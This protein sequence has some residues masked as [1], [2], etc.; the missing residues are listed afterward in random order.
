MFGTFDPNK[1][2]D[3]QTNQ[4]KGRYNKTKIDVILS[5]GLVMIF[6]ACY[7]FCLLCLQKLKL[8]LL[9]FQGFGEKNIRLA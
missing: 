7:W 4:R 5:E 8:F 6:M 3:K 2:P 9:S 1:V